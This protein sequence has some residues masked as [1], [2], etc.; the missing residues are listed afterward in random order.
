MG[1]AISSELYS[2]QEVCVICIQEARKKARVLE[3]V[4][5]CAESGAASHLWLQV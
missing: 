3:L 1:F 5:G 4:E 2:E